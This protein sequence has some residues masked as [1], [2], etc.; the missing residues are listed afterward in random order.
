[1]LGFILGQD[2]YCDGYAVC[3]DSRGGQ[4]VSGDASGALWGVIVGAIRASRARIQ[5]R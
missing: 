1:M 3:A 5:I 4:A 2:D